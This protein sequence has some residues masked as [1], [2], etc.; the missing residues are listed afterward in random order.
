MGKKLIKIDREKCDG[1][2]LCVTACHEGAIAIVDGKAEL[3]SESLCDGLGDCL[4]AC[5]RDAITITEVEAGHHGRH[6]HGH[7]HG[8][9]QHHAHQGCPG[10]MMRELGKKEQPSAPVAGSQPVVIRPETTQWPLQ[11]HLVPSTAPFFKGRELVLVSTC[12]PIACPD[13]NWRYIRGRALVIACPKLDQTEGY[14]EKLREIIE[15]A[16]TE[17]VYVLRM[18]V[19]C[20]RGLLRL[21]D[22]A[23][24]GLARRPVVEEVIVGIEGGI[25]GTSTVGA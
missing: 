19:P 23:L 14:V 22:E 16:G 9:G 18:E 4:G 2:G 13:V 20:C 21:L 8:H 7:H 6:E 24:E 25:L 10:A 1:C 11:L 15:N 17:K 3:V 5:P 12:A